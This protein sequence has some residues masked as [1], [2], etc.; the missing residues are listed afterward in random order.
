MSSEVRNSE[1]V[2]WR[3]KVALP[4]VLRNSGAVR[5]PRQLQDAKAASARLPAWAKCEVS[6][7]KAI[8]GIWDHIVWV[9]KYSG[10]YSRH[11][12]AFRA[13]RVT[14]SAAP[15]QKNAH[16]SV[17]LGAL[18]KESWVSQGR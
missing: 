9:I 11:V 5:S 10:P 7:G 18:G 12:E 13:A 6:G 4:D 2:V 14:V 1:E 16:T 17:A 3:P 15:S 8:L